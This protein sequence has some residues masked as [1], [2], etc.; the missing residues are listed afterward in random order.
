[1]KII[2][3]FLSEAE[4]SPETIT[5]F[6]DAAEELYG[7]LLREFKNIAEI[8]DLDDSPTQFHIHVSATRHLGIVTTLLRKKLKHYRVAERVTVERL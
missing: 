3:V 8:R 1:M 4:P 7:K 6:D 5:L 2:R